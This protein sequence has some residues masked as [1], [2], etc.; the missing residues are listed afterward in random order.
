MRVFTLPSIL[1][2]ARKTP[3]IPRTCS[4]RWIYNNHCKNKSTAHLK[5]DVF[6]WIWLL[7]FPS[8][9]FWSFCFKSP[10]K[11]CMLCISWWR[12][13][14][15]CPLQGLSLMMEYPLSQPHW[16]TCTVA[17]WDKGKQWPSQRGGCSVVFLVSALMVNHW[18]GLMWV[19][20]SESHRDGKVQPPV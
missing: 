20:N 12:Q 13:V 4:A 9:L 7:F 10:S 5:A 1:W 3:L 19:L 14:V 2:L 11:P 15:Q 17:P 6:I 18:V 8:S 16:M